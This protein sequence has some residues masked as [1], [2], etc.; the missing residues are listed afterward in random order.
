MKTL[1]S[2]D[3]ADMIGHWSETPTNGYL[4][5]SYGQNFNSDLQLPQQVASANSLILKLRKDVEVLQVLP[6]DAVNIYAN[7]KGN[8]GM[9]VYLSVVGKEFYLG[10]SDS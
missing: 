3:V 1:N 6:D 5:S 2:Q 4:G 9:S 10:N 7:P 8:D